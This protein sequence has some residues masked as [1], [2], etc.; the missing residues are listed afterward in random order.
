MAIDFSKGVG[1]KILDQLQ[2]E[3]VAWLTTTSVDGTPQPRLIWFLWQDEGV[4]FYSQPGAAKV[5]HIARNPRIALHFNSDAAGNTSRVL[6]GTAAPAPDAPGMAENQ[7]YVAKYRTA[8][9]GINQTPESL[10]AAFTLAYR[11]RPERIRGW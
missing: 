10:A 9:A 2:S 8:M 3:Q 11:I 1:P 6:T 4:L 7:E 5:S